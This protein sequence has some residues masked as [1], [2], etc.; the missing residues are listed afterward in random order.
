MFTLFASK[1]QTNCTWCL[2]SSS[3][4]L[5]L[6]P[7]GALGVMRAETRTRRRKRPAALEW[8]GESQLGGSLEARWRRQA[9]W[10]GRATS[11]RERNNNERQSI[12]A[13]PRDA[14][15]SSCRNQVVRHSHRR[16]SGGGRKQSHSAGQCRG[17]KVWTTSESGV[18]YGC[19][20]YYGQL[21]T[22]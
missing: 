1:P 9:A 13:A 5:C 15:A 14:C 10:R 4:V 8:S 18:H 20:Q 17:A 3:G 7:L 2:E 12:N 19:A 16:Q 21:P 11:G 22:S 6:A